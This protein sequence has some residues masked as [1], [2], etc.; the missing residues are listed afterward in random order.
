MQY[1]F[2]LAKSWCCVLLTALFY[3]TRVTF[4]LL[5]YVARLRPVKIVFITGSKAESVRYYINIFDQLRFL[6]GFYGLYLRL[7]SF[8]GFRGCQSNTIGVLYIMRRMVDYICSIQVEFR[9]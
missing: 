9:V 7:L 4:L 6:T 5:K 1:S 3:C 2:L 8:T